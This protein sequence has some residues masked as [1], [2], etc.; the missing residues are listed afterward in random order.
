M[1]GLLASALLPGQ[2]RKRAWSSVWPL[3]WLST[4]NLCPIQRWSAP[5]LMIHVH[6]ARSTNRHLTLRSAARWSSSI[7]RST[8]ESVAL[9]DLCVIEIEHQYASDDD[10]TA[11]ERFRAA[12]TL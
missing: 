8:S 3:C 1:G 6:R 11:L 10:V 4:I 7:S 12:F 5:I 9:P 2:N